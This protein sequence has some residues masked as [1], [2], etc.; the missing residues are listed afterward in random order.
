MRADGTLVECMPVMSEVWRH[1]AAPGFARRRIIDAR[2][3]LT[4]RS[5][6]QRAPVDAVEQ[7]NMFLE[8]TQTYLLRPDRR[9]R[10]AL[11][12]DNAAV[13]SFISLENR[14]EASGSSRPVLTKCSESRR[15]ASPLLLGSSPA[16]RR[17]QAETRRRRGALMQR[18]RFRHGSVPREWPFHGWRQ[19]QLDSFMLYVEGDTSFPFE[20][21]PVLFLGENQG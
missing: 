4:L 11:R 10:S 9:M 14:C 5:S 7:E 16:V 1:A 21:P 19:S 13:S 8:L 12:F 6:R 20:K 18:A 15:S 2:L 3:A 17:H